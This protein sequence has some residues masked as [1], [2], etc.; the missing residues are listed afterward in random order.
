MFDKKGM[1]QIAHQP[2]RVLPSEKHK[3][4][5]SLEI[6]ARP[7]GLGA[8]HSDVTA[9][10]GRGWGDGEVIAPSNS[11]GHAKELLSVPSKTT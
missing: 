2:R 1:R 6:P 10:A 8:S 9:P 5:N 3:L 4:G 11:A 7:A